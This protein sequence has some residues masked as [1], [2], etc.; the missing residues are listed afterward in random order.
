M[1]LSDENVLDAAFANNDN[2][3]YVTEKEEESDND[4]L[5]I[6]IILLACLL[7]VTIA[8]IVYCKVKSK[9]SQDEAP[10]FAIQSYDLSEAQGNS[11][12]VRETETNKQE[13]KIQPNEILSSC[14]I[15]DDASDVELEDQ[16]KNLKKHLGQG[17]STRNKFTLRKLP[18]WG[19]QIDENQI[20]FEWPTQDMIADIDSDTRLESL[21]FMD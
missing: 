21:E 6:M 2:V 9:R 18:L 5:L 17:N 15:Y 11:D 14:R 20:D 19:K 12:D 1:I 3:T 10:K 13:S 16:L 7:I 4:F 8:I